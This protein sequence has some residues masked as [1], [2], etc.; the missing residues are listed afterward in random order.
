[1]PSAPHTPAPI[2]RVLID[3][4]RTLRTGG[5]SGIPRVARNLARRAPALAPAMG[6]EALPIAWS[7]GR[8]HRVDPAALRAEQPV[9]R[10]AAKGFRGR[11]RAIRRG[12]KSRL[13]A[14]FTLAPAPNAPGLVASADFAA[15]PSRP[16][17]VKRFAPARRAWRSFRHR[18][19]DRCARWIGG[20]GP[21]VTVGPADLLLLPEGLSTLE[22]AAGVE[23]A[24]AAG[25]RCAVVMY[26]L[27]PVR[28]PHTTNHDTPALFARFLDLTLRSAD[29]VVGIS[30]A[31]RDDFAQWLA[32]RAADHP[33]PRAADIHL[34][35]FHL[36]AD[37]DRGQVRHVPRER[38][39]AVLR[40]ASAAPLYLMVSTLEPRKNHALL[41]DAF[42]ALWSARP[43][44]PGP[45]L[46]LIGQPGWRVGELLDRL[47]RHPEL[48]RRLHWF[49]DANDAEVEA[50]YAAA[51][52][53]IMPSIAEGFGLPIV[54]ALTRGTPVLASDLPVHRELADGFARWF[55]PTD[56]AALRALLEA[57]LAGG[58]PADAAA[59][60]GFSWPDWDQAT[61]DLL[62]RLLAALGPAPLG[63]PARP[64]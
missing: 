14:L 5:T 55:P 40:A 62:R 30:R 51:R 19:E 36:G 33:H 53:V 38:V 13:A 25:A 10:R 61:Q 42:D 16:P 27:I 28:F 60:A 11:W 48:N 9:W 56:A 2:R 32:E 12:I 1:L 18:V 3:C 44:Q 41:L 37:M 58:T 39:L 29:A 22:A 52:A 26:D 46:V 21:A 35:W 15:A 54:E 4:T 64:A 49:P 6:L 47:A 59:P 63:S 23:H 43:N 24:R 20:L 31:T 8:W 45:A 17:R 57:D 34:D 50:A 7:A